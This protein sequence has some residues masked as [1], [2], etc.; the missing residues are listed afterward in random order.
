M[1]VEG[2]GGGVEALG[3]LEGVDGVDGVKELGGAG[4]FVGLQGADEVEVEVGKKGEVLG[5][6][7]KLLHAVFAE[8]TL[9]GGVGVEDDLDGVDFADGHEGDFGVGAVGSAAG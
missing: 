4:G 3:D 1:L 6:L 5:F 7:L 9:A 8:E 2:G